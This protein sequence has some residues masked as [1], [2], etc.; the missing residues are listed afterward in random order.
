MTTAP[1]LAPVPAPSGLLRG[2]TYQIYIV[3]FMGMVAMMDQY[4][5]SIEST[6]IPYL[7]ADYHITAAQFAALKARFLIVTFFVFGLNALNDLLGR[8]P[9]IL[10]LILLMGVSSLGI[11]LFTPSLLWFMVFYAAAMFATVSNMWTIPVGEEAPAA[12]RARYTATVFAISLIPLQAYVPLYLLQ[13]L[14][15]NWRWMY[16]ITFVFML[17][18]L[19]TW[20]FM[21]ETGRYREV[22]AA[23]PQPLGW[24][25]LIGLNRF[26][27]ADVRYIALATAIA[28]GVLIVMTLVFWAG[29][30]FMQVRGY[31]LAQW[32]TV[33]FSLLTLEIVGGLSGGW[34]MDRLGRNRMFVAAGLGLALALAALGLAPA[35]LLA[36]VYVCA[37]FFIGIISAWLFVYIPEIFPTERR[38]TC[39]GWVMSLARLSYVL[40][41]AL[42]SL[43]LRTFPTMTGFWVAAGLFMLIPTGL[44]LLARPFETRALELE[45]IAERR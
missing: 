44:V 17:P 42:A 38:G 29:Y 18:T 21:R 10:V 43:L 40:G 36:P 24:R 3:A 11:V 15:L 20:L 16:G 1:T 12:R 45:E 9:A 14:G 28:T 27:R 31:T 13:H 2:R 19:V 22:K 37:G 6:A 34:L 30:F 33:M 25:D 8:K 7:L 5:S 41:P 23:R 39:T 4:L 26:A 32:S 35:G